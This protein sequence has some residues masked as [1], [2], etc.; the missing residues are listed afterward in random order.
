M[1]DLIT[2]TPDQR[3]RAERMVGVGMDVGQTAYLLARYES[4]LAELER[5]RAV[6][7]A[8]SDLIDWYEDELE[9]SSRD[10]ASL[11]EDFLELM[12][13]LDAAKEKA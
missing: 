6:V 7:N 12:Q 5:L 1:S 9:L 8:Q 3:Q 13:A 2:P 4:T 10:E 11:P